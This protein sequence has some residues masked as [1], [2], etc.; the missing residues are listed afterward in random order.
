MASFRLI[1]YI[2]FLIIIHE[3]GHFLTAKVFNI[4]LDKIYI[5]PLGGIAK[6][7]IPYN[8]SRIKELIILV[9]GP[10]FQEIAKVILIYIFPQYTNIISTYHYG[11]LLFNL[12]PISIR[13]RKNS[14]YIFI[15]FRT[16]QKIF[17]NININKL[18]NFIN[19]LY[20]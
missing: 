14:K 12:L 7:Y 18:S 3:L 16:I 10:M 15:I 8:Y 4:E 1:F 5:Y 6:F 17:K 20:N 11:I 2:F 19:N 9:N 13:W